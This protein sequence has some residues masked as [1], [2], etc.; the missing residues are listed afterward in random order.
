MRVSVVDEVNGY[1][2]LPVPDGCAGA[3]TCSA[4]A[5][6]APSV[7]AYTFNYNDCLGSGSFATVYRGY[8]RGRSVAVK[9]TRI[10]RGGA[11]SARRAQKICRIP[12]NLPLTTTAAVDLRRVESQPNG[13]K[14]KEHLFAEIK[15]MRRLRH[16]NIVSLEDD[17]IHEKT[18][19]ILYVFLEYCSG[20]DF[21]AYIKS[22]KRLSERQAHLFMRQLAEGLRYLHQQGVV[23]RDLKPH[24]LLLSDRGAS[25]VLKI[26]DFGFARVL[27]P[28]ALADTV[29]GSPLYMAPEILFSHKYTD[30]ADLWSTG[31]VLHEMLTGRPPFQ[32]DSTVQLFD[33]LRTTPVVALP[34]DVEASEAL[35]DLVR[36]L[37]TVG[38][39]ERISWERFL[40]HPWIVGTAV[41][42]A[43]LQ[44]AAAA[45]EVTPPAP[46]GAAVAHVRRQSVQVGLV[47]RPATSTFGSFESIGGGDTDPARSGDS[48]AL[49]PAAD[50]RLS[51][52][53]E[54][55]HRRATA[56]AEL[57]E[58]RSEA[59]YAAEAIALCHWCLEITRGAMLSAQRRVESDPAVREA[60][61]RQNSRVRC[62]VDL[63]AALRAECLA[64]V[65][66]YRGQVQLSG[67]QGQV[68]VATPERV[69]Y[70]HAMSLGR[71]A[72]VDELMGHEDKALAEYTAGI[73][74]LECLYQAAEDKADKA[75]VMD[76]IE[77]FRRRQ[78]ETMRM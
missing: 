47:A 24:N 35:R 78:Q 70:Q 30:K 58:L 63:L 59:G 68:A 54:Q 56:L 17:E 67:A 43:G 40:G 23:H 15:I 1:D 13:D 25:A 73:S 44:Q 50:E 3:P 14:L 69:V 38:T 45:F 72:G 12:G 16:P 49:P 37:L 46:Q 36:G 77:M 52:D 21:A 75:S 60:A 39:A 6:L 48:P 51:A 42:P 32:V 29:C 10:A 57:A 8:G 11:I 2:V 27:N 7:G 19:N 53:L 28:E 66:K 62:A 9:G 64:A 18:R 31:A 71:A 26:A 41:V 22:A 5:E 74:L 33:R 65:G 61:A 55:W 76:Y 34:G 4:V 20:G